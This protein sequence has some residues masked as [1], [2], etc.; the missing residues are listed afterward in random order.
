MDLHRIA[1]SFAP[2]GRSVL[3]GRSGWSMVWLWDVFTEWPLRVLD[4]A[5]DFSITDLAFS[6]DG[7]LA[8]TGNSD[9]RAV[10]W[11]VETG[12]AVRTLEG[13]TS[14]VSVV[15]FSPDGMRL[16]TGSID[17]TVR[18]WDIS[19]R[20]V[21]LEFLGHEG[22]VNAATF[23][24]DGTMVAT[25]GSD[26]TVRLWDVRWDSPVVYF[27]WAGGISGIGAREPDG[28]RVDHR[29]PNL[30]RY[31]LG[32]E[33][34]EAIPEDLVRAEFESGSEVAIEFSRYAWRADVVLSLEISSDLVF[35]EVIA[36]A[37]GAEPMKSV[38]EASAEV[39]DESASG[40][41]FRV[42][43]VPYPEAGA[44]KPT[45]FFYRLSGSLM[46]EEQ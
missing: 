42:R 7:K 1:V 43:V 20:R 30:S 41:G 46:D 39:D 5:H 26:R 36:Q 16:L 34:T 38:Q 10:L 23:S 8:I 14:S 32:I 15:G 31:A 18:V 21:V 28:T 29:Y 19:A 6:P 37:E 17:E 9:A 3:G 2:D 12:D 45:S 24:P 11:D 4:G 25:G 44:G 33:A 13:H 22:P 27:D 40:A 35:W